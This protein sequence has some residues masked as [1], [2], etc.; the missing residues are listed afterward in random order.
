M[1]IV[2]AITVLAGKVLLFLFLFFVI[3][4][5]EELIFISYAAEDASLKE[6]LIKETISYD[7]VKIIVG[8]FQRMTNITSQTLNQGASADRI[9]LD[10][11]L[12]SKGF[13][14]YTMLYP[15]FED[16]SLKVS[17][18]FPADELD[19]YLKLFFM[20]FSS[21][22]SVRTIVVTPNASSEPFA[23][24]RAWVVTAK[25]LPRSTIRSTSV[26]R[27]QKPS[28]SCSCTFQPCSSLAWCFG[29]FWSA[30]NLPSNAAEKSEKKVDATMK[31]WACKSKAI[32]S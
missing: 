5:I 12:A 3:Y 27:H 31:S 13:E 21:R 18:S 26:L 17:V 22:T 7:E 6:Y 14:L 8:R 11:Y 29:S 4:I 20:L 23:M 24:A 25:F 19:L 28:S 16:Y 1:K 2:K 15:I 32:W 30:S 10:C 9:I